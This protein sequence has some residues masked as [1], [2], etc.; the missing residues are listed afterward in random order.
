MHNIE[1]LH[2]ADA[3][4]QV[5]AGLYEKAQK[6]LNKAAETINAAVKLGQWYIT[7]D[8]HLEP[9]VKKTLETKGYKVSSGSD[10]NEF[11]TTISWALVV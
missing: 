11:Y 7:L 8:C 4:K 2:A 6:Q 10:R 3:R 1:L 5:E 9:S